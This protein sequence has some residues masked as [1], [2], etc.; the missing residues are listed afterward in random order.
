MSVA[1]SI[2][3]V[4]LL[5]KETVLRLF[6]PMYLRLPA[7]GT[8]IAD[9]VSL[10][11]FLVL[12][13]LVFIGFT[14]PRD[15]LSNLLPLTIWT[16]WWIVLV[17]LIGLVGNF[18]HWLN[19][20]TGP[21]RLI[22]GETP[23]PAPLRLPEA[24]GV[25]PGLALFLLYFSFFIADPAPSDPDRLALVVTLYWVFTFCGMT[26]FGAGP[27][28]ER[29]EPFS[30][31]FSLL[32]RVALFGD[33]RKSAIGLPGWALALT[34]PH[35]LGLG[36]FALTLL[37]AGSFDGLKESFW[38]MGMIGV[39]PLEFPGRS[40][41][42]ASSLVGLML[43]VTALTFGFAAVVWAGRAFAQKAG[44]GGPLPS[45]A[46]CF[47]LFAPAVLPIA[48][49]YHISHFLISFLIEGQYLLAAIGDPYAK[50]ANFFGLADI[51]VTTGFLNAIDSVNR[52]WLTQAGVVVA[53]HILSVLVSH[54]AALQLFGEPRR[55]AFSQIPMGLFMVAYTLFGLWLLATPRGV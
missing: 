18:W 27:W 43:S 51:R 11:S 33:G 40:A 4:S 29:C 30:I 21:Y 55:A 13:L 32:S 22:F 8:H 2:L 28:L 45:W 5:G 39:N 41:V 35:A 48:L 3:V 47:A 6:R 52:I 23:G 7:G 1:A 49:G 42:I 14:G 25:W 19:P 12:V 15:P 26:L 20:W 17:S 10:M 31:A 34:G 24:L 50:G 38:W 46:D 37:A 44:S 54:R 53:G 9:L 36:V 16:G